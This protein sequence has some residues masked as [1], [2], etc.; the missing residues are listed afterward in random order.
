MCDPI[1]ETV[2]K[3]QPHYSYSQTSRKNATPFRGTSPLAHYYEEPS[4]LGTGFWS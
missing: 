4:L 2:L 3:M 1:L